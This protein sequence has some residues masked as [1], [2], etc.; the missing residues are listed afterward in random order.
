MKNKILNIIIRKGLLIGLLIMGC[1]GVSCIDNIDPD[2]LI[3]ED[4]EKDYKWASF[5]KSMQLSIVPLGQNQYQ[6]TDD[7]H[8]NNYAG[9]IGEMQDWNNDNNSLTYF[10]SNSLKWQDDMFHVT[11]GT[12]GDE[13]VAP[14][15]FPSWNMIRKKAGESSILYSFAQILKIM[16]AHRASDT[17]GPLP[18][19]GYGEEANPKYNSQEEIYYSFF[20]ELN[21]AIEQLTEA[22]N[23]NPDSKPIEGSD[24]MYGSDLGSWIKFA[25]SL[26]L[27]LAMR[28]SYVDPEKAKQYAEEAVQHSVG[29]IELNAENAALREAYGIPQYRHPLNRITL[30]FKEPAMGASMDSYMNG[31]NDPRLPFYFTATTN[32]AYR[33][34]HGVPTGISNP[35]NYSGKPSIPAIAYGADLV[36]LSAAEVAFLRAEGALNNWN[37][38]GTAESFYKKG[39]EL[40]MQS[41]GIDNGTITNYI[42]NDSATP[43][44][45]TDQISSNSIPAVSNVTIK[46]NENSTTEQKLEKIM[47]QKWIALYP[48][49]QEA[50]AEHR[51]TGYP[52]LFQITN[53]RS[54]SGSIGGVVSS[55]DGVRRIPFPSTEYT[56]NREYVEEAITNYLNGTDAA[57]TKLW[58]D[59]K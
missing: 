17:Y 30:I 15:S 36:F 52:K 10:F 6:L 28:I 55:A 57:S 24:F 35:K 53:N 37:M 43:I 42:N 40:S 41:Y 22:Y 54:S 21:V 1:V 23:Q 56:T 48:N 11:Y 5:I 50:W 9:Y 26:K 34:Y 19:F 7:L 8:G 45:Y 4:L 51:R 3:D 27:R 2:K 59:V 12:K 31:Y 33:D 25:N 13:T 14:G 39:I 20:E 16:Q 44:A 32:T 38:G 58:W 49:G 47:T 46:W 18:Y 29:V